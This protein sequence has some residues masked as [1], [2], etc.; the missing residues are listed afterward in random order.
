[1]VFVS[2]G[3]H[4][5]LKPQ[6]KVCF[7]YFV[8]FVLLFFIKHL[9]TPESE[10]AKCIHRNKP[11]ILDKKKEHQKTE[12]MTDGTGGSAVYQNDTDTDL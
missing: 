12:E 7:T 3:F 1:M 2:S 9:L 6:I 11:G 5:Q 8:H 4:S 10:M